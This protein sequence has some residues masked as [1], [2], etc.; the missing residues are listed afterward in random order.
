MYIKSNFYMFMMK[1]RIVLKKKEEIVTSVSVFDGE[2]LVRVFNA[3]E[4]G[5]S[6]KEQAE[7]L[8]ERKGYTLK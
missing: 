3:K 4:D 6:F 7:R 5:D 2:T 8:A 1:K